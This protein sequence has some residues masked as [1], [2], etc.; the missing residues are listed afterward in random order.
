M[1]NSG[2]TLIELMVVLG[3]IGMLAVVAVP[4]YFTQFEKAKQ[5]QTA[6]QLQRLQSALDAFRL[7]HGR[8]PTEQEGLKALVE[9]PAQ[10]DQYPDDGYLKRSTVPKDAWGNAFVYRRDSNEYTLYSTGSDGQ[11]GGEGQAQDIYVD[12]FQE[13]IER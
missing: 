1:N 8:Y 10:L 2:F 5:T 13:F 9:K 12:N 7:D 6:L 4:T 11:K 3:I